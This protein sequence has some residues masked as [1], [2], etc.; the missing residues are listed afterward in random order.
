MN[1]WWLFLLAQSN[2]GYCE[3]VPS[4]GLLMLRCEENR[5]TAQGTWTVYPAEPSSMEARD[6][7]WDPPG[8]GKAS[9]FP[10]T[11]W[12]EIPRRPSAF[13][14]EHNHPGRTITR[15]KLP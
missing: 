10:P 12:S 11:A 5:R 13:G 14:S 3:R 2:E 1:E 15:R 4:R 6:K 7:G 9:I 8:R